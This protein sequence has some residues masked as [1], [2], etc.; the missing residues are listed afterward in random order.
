MREGVSTRPKRSV[1]RGGRGRASDMSVPLRDPHNDLLVAVR[2]PPS[3]DLEA[4]LSLPVRT[5]CGTRRA[6]RVSGAFALGRWPFLT[7]GGRAWQK[8]TAKLGLC[9][10]LCAGALSSWR[11]TLER[12]GWLRRGSAEDWEH[13]V[14]SL[15]F[16][17]VW[18][19]T[20]ATRSAGQ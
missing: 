14:Q 8:S 10:K 20:P 3:L 7:S 16:V 15:G 18:A 9:Q 6:P 1:C 2:L 13:C 17:L 11:R 5:L 12:L 19:G 4:A